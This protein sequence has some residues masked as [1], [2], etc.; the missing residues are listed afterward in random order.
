MTDWPFLNNGRLREALER[1]RE[2]HR[3]DMNKKDEAHRQDMK[4]LLQSLREMF[5]NEQAVVSEDLVLKLL[6]RFVK[7][8]N[9]TL[10]KRMIFLKKEM[11][12][13]QQTNQKHLF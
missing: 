13:T 8:K 1:L 3:D 10:L 2:A 4:E 7:E 12:L 6:A 9:K 11:N 5:S